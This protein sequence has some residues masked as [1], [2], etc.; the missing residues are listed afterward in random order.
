MDF[1]NTN[2]KTF[3]ISFPLRKRGIE[4]DFFVVAEVKEGQLRS[5]ISCQC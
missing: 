3:L 5:R 1:P 2:D 4:G